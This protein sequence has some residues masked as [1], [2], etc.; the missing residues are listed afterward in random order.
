MDEN[1]NPHNS[2]SMHEQADNA[3][4]NH[5]LASCITELAGFKEKYARLGSDFENYKRRM[6]KEKY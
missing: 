5:E 1:N 6:E 4:T 3:G 2:A